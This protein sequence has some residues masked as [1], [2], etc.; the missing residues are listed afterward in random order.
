MKTLIKVAAT[1][2]VFMMPLAGWGEVIPKVTP[3][4]AE[5]FKD[6]RHSFIAA[7]VLWVFYHEMGHALIHQMD[8][9]VLG[10]EEDAADHLAILLSDSLWDEDHADIINSYAS[11]AFWLFGETAEEK[12]PWWDE[13]STDQ[14]RH[15]AVACLYYGGAPED[16]DYVLEA[17]GLP[18]ERAELCIFEREQV[19]HAWGTVLDE[20]SSGKFS[21]KMSFKNEAEA[22]NESGTAQFVASVLAEEVEN[23]NKDFSFEH[24]ITVKFLPCGEENA[25]YNP[26]EY[27]VHI[28]TEYSDLI[29][30]LYKS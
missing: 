24:E 23:L 18:E 30:R 14:Q 27:E 20:L 22:E 10:K 1:S 28:C 12:A 26:E 11:S 9:P 19:E 3:K 4:P 25:F 8:L 13:H 21:K 17:V 2:L 29:D 16:R 6:E 7:N 5:T 15:F